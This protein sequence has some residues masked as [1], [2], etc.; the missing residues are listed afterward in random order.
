MEGGDLITAYESTIYRLKVA[1]G[2]LE[3]SR[4][5]LQLRRWRSAGDNEQ[6]AADVHIQTDCGDEKVR[7]ERSFRSSWSHAR[8][9]QSGR[10]HAGREKPADRNRGARPQAA[11]DAVG[12]PR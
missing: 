8:F 12:F 9:H 10:A 2:F 7:R 5:D 6:I 3:E 11:F 4:Q 1:Q